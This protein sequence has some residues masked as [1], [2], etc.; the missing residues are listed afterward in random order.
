[1]PKGY[2]WRGWYRGVLVRGIQPYR[3]TFLCIEVLA[4]ARECCV[5]SCKQLLLLTCESYLSSAHRVVLG[6]NGIEELLPLGPLSVD[7][8]ARL[9]V[10]C[11]ELAANIDKVVNSMALSVYA[12]HLRQ[13][14]FLNFRVVSQGTSYA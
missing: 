10:A 6:R 2:A 14:S 5:T 1:M 4:Y 12:L 3:P 7:E 13:L 9:Q 11:K 8:R